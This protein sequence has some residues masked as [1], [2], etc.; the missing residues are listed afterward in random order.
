MEPQPQYSNKILTAAEVSENTSLDRL[1]RMTEM[2]GR[3]IADHLSSDSLTPER[4]EVIEDLKIAISDA[5]K[6]F[7]T[8]TVL[9]R[10]E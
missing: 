3:I 4:R 9:K 10:H 7:T 1:K 2:C 5:K 6:I 8:V